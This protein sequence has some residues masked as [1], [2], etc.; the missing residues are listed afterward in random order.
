MVSN[1]GRELTDHRINT[2]KLND[3]V[4]FFIMSCFV[5]L[6]KPDADIFKISLDI[7]Q[8]PAEEVAYIED[9]PMFVQVAESVGIFG[10]V[11]NDYEDTKE[12]LAGFGLKL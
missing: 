3:F 8:V 1:E 5:H 7:A 12:R 2:Y 10:I 9:R 6:R 11:H 4:D